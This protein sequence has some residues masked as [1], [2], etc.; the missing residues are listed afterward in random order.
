MCLT[1][2][3]RVHSQSSA[4]RNCATQSKM[5]EASELCGYLS[6]RF[7]TRCMHAARWKERDPDLLRLSTRSPGI[8]GMSVKIPTVETGAAVGGLCGGRGTCGR[9]EEDGSEVG[10]VVPLETLRS[11]PLVVEDLVTSAFLCRLFT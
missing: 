3:R 9:E 2:P 1:L 5:C 6:T 11:L 10:A 7:S 8:E 4:G